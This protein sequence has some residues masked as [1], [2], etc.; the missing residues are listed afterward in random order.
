MRTK[1]W[2]GLCLL[3]LAPLETALAQQ[4]GPTDRPGWNQLRQRFEKEAPQVGQPLPD[5]EG[6]DE[7]G[8]P[9]RLGQLKGRYTVLVFGCL[10]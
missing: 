9:F 10:T 3:A 5:L 2:L 8:R 6:F 1:T 4:A 7:K